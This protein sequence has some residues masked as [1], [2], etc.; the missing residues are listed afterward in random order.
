MDASWL[1]MLE[2]YAIDDAQRGAAY[3]DATA[4]QRQLLKTAIAYHA[5]QGESP[6]AAS[7]FCEYKSKGFWHRCHSAPAPTLVILCGEEYNSPARLVAAAMPALLASV[8]QI[9]FMQIGATPPALLVA[10]ELLGMEEAYALP[11]LDTA[12]ELLSYLQNAP[13]HAHNQRLLL[14]HPQKSLSPLLPLV[15]DLHIPHMEEAKAPHIFMPPTLSTAMKD[16][17]HYAHP[18]AVIVT[19]PFDFAHAYYGTEKPSLNLLS[20]AI[21]Q[22]TT[23]YDQHFTEGLEACWHTPHLDKNFFLN[24]YTMAGTT[25]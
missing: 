8:P 4:E 14:L 19:S 15:Q 25:L 18:D 12:R 11:S 6:H 9:L 3:E 1:E 23:L 5:L 22:G 17:V 24:H 20:Q 2:P 7:Q 16:K 10:L 21:C 13:V